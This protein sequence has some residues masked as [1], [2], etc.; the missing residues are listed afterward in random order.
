MNPSSADIVD[1]GGIVFSERMLH[2]KVPVDGIR[3]LLLRWNPV[4]SLGESVRLAQNGDAG[5]ASRKKAAIGQEV[6]RQRHNSPRPSDVFG[7]TDLRR[8]RQS[9][10][11]VVKRIVGQAKATAD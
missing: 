5:A 7:R 1:F 10:D 3:I 4:R 11:V 9:A 8:Y 2:P 6:S